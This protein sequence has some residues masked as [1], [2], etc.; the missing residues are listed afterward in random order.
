MYEGHYDLHHGDGKT[1]LLELVKQFCGQQENVYEMATT[2]DVEGLDE[3]ALKHLRDH[4]NTALFKSDTINHIS[5]ALQVLGVVVD[6]VY[7]DM[8]TMENDTTGTMV[9]GADMWPRRAMACEAAVKLLV[10][11]KDMEDQDDG[12]TAESVVRKGLALLCCNF[13]IFGQEFAI[14]MLGEKGVKFRL[15]KKFGKI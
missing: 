14:Y 1:P 5:L 7:R 15:G 11:L 4:V 8:A 3:L 6:V 10:K 12:E 13:P 2:F 9:V